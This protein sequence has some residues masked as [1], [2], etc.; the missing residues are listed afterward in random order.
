MSENIRK[1]SNIVAN[2][3]QN[4]QENKNKDSQG[5]MNIVRAYDVGSRVQKN[6]GY[7]KK[8]K[9]FAKHYFENY[10]NVD[11]WV[12]NMFSK[13]QLAQ[14]AGDTSVDSLWGKVKNQVMP[15]SGYKN[16]SELGYMANEM[17]A[18]LPPPPPTMKA[19]AGT[20]DGV[21]MMFDPMTGEKVA[22]TIATESAGAS[23]GAG[24]G[25]GAGA[26]SI[27][28]GPILAILAGL[29]YG[30]NKK[31]TTLNRWFKK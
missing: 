5:L 23:A 31:G 30:I 10:E 22:S 12:K 26:S 4:N 13:D 14:M 17:G 16:T 2:W 24:A 11:P 21:P 15:S 19:T 27:G 1:N 29:G 25:S 18:T 7:S 6:L 9:E 8:G 20:V 28:L 3:W